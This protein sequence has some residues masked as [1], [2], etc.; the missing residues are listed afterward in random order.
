MKILAQWNRAVARRSFVF[1]PICFNNIL[2][3][4]FHSTFSTLALWK[5]KAF[6]LFRRFTCVF[7]IC[8]IH[9][10]VFFFPA[11][12][13]VGIES[14]SRHTWGQ[15]W[16]V[17]MA[18]KKFFFLSLVLCFCGKNV[19]VEKLLM[20]FNQNIEFSDTKHRRLWRETFPDEKVSCVFWFCFLFIS[21][22]CVL[23]C[24]AI[25]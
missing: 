8:L 5:R 4:L 12:A 25:N 6:S 21:V 14:F 3:F 22:S 1:Q 9:Q 15:N 17:K 13:S 19:C 16:R 18:Q 10:K 20:H 2:F 23:C 11:S 7:F 24:Y